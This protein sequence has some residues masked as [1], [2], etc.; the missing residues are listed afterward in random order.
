MLQCPKCNA[1]LSPEELSGVSVDACSTC[2]GLWLDRSRLDNYVA[3]YLVAS[4][5]HKHPAA[6]LEKPSAPTHLRCPR[7]QT[8][9]LNLVKFREVAVEACPTCQGVFL[10][11]GEA[12]RIAKRTLLAT[13]QSDMPAA[14]VYIQQRPRV[15]GDWRSMAAKCPHCGRTIYNQKVKNCGFCHGILPENLLLA[16]DHVEELD[17]TTEDIAKRHGDFMQRHAEYMAELKAKLEGT[18]LTET[19]HRATSIRVSKNGH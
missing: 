18:P 8:Q 1:S 9:T 4:G 10:D 12:E 15:E 16:K 14:R 3:N 11:R 7:C 13:K 17:K 5:F 6:L 19:P 2:G